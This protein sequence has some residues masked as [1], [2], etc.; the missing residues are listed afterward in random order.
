MESKICVWISLTVVIGLWNSLV[1]NTSA[2]DNMILLDAHMT[3]PCKSSNFHNNE[4]YLISIQTTLFPSQTMASGYQTS[5]V[6]DQT[7]GCSV[8]NYHVVHGTSCVVTLG[9]PVCRSYSRVLHKAPP[10]LNLSGHCY[11]GRD[12]SELSRK[13]WGQWPEGPSNPL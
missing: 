11:S 9:F 5:F 7:R 2:V 3:D 10:L 1:H 8:M 12:P 6:R 4:N 13:T